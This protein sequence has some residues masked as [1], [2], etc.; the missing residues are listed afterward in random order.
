MRA[1]S[2]LWMT[3]CGRMFAISGTIFW[4][5]SQ[6]LNPRY[7]LF[8]SAGMWVSE[9]S[10]TWRLSFPAR[11]PAEWH[12]VMLSAVAPNAVAVR[13]RRRSNGSKNR[14]GMLPQL[15]NHLRG[16]QENFAEHF[17]G[18]ITDAG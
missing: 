3:A 17:A 5:F 16:A 7:S 11:L 14:P 12:P 8:L 4:R 1:A 9:M 18:R 13:K 2:P 10:A 15:N 6:G